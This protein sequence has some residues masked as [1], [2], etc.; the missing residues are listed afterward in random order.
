MKSKKLYGQWLSLT[1]LSVFTLTVKGQV[2]SYGLQPILKSAYDSIVDLNPHLRLVNLENAIPEIILDIRY[3]TTGNFIGKQAYELPMAFAREDVS[4][5]LKAVVQELKEENLG[6]KIF[7]AYRPYSVTVLFYETFPDTTFVASPF[8]GS[9]H[10][11]GAAVDVTLVDLST[12]LELDMGTAFDEFSEISHPEFKDLPKETLENRNK[13]R[14]VMEKNGFSIYPTEWWH[15]DYRD[16]EK[17]NIL[18][19]PFSEI[20]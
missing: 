16:W 3:A 17:Y 12:N 2:N 6:L 1:L 8:T 20:N 14:K 19:V 15:F 9:R 5:A 18:D 7:D 4:I 10:N 13:L 11:R